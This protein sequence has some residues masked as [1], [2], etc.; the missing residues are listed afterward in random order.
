MRNVRAIESSL[1][2]YLLEF[3][4]VPGGRFS[5]DE[6]VKW[7]YTGSPLLN[8]IF[9]ARFGSDPKSQIEDVLAFYCQ[10]NL[11]VTWMAGPSGTPKNLGQLLQPFGFSSASQWSGMS[12]SLD[13]TAPIPAPDGFSCQR[14][15]SKQ[16]LAHW[17]SIARPAFNLT[18]NTEASFTTIFNPLL[19]G[20]RAP[21][22][23]YLGTLNGNPCVTCF[24]FRQVSTVGVFWV[25]TAQ[26][27]RK[28]GLATA[29]TYQALQAARQQGARLAVLHATP[30]GTPLYAKMGFRTKCTFN[31]YHR[32]PENV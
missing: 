15:R 17:A 32:L 25:A 4:K 19:L 3:G 16:D 8:R 10:R 28:R 26:H 18:P 13:Q 1:Y 21:F 27:A 6:T 22:Q 11:P 31:L 20:K 2:D 24:C 30:M 9:D 12:L 23:G 29:L 7:T 5:T 14:V